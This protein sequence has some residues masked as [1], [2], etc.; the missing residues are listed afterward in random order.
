M[1]IK[2]PAAHSAC[3][4]TCNN[5]KL[6]VS[7]EQ[8]IDFSTRTESVARICESLR[9]PYSR[10][11][12]KGFVD[13][14]D[15]ASYRH[16]ILA[17]RWLE[18]NY[19]DGPDLVLL[20][21]RVTELYYLGLED[22]DKA[23]ITEDDIGLEDL[24]RLVDSHMFAAYN[25]AQYE[26]AR[27][28]IHDDIPTN[29][30]S[31]RH[32]F[33]P[34]EEAEQVPES[35]R[36]ATQYV[37]F[38]VLEANTASWEFQEFELPW[39]YKRRIVRVKVQFSVDDLSTHAERVSRRLALRDKRRRKRRRRFEEHEK[40]RVEM[41][42]G[43]EKK[44]AMREEREVK[45][46]EAAARKA[47]DQ[48]K[49]IPKRVREDAIKAQRDK[50]NV[51]LQSGVNAA[52]RRKLSQG[53]KRQVQ[54]QSLR[55]R[56]KALLIGGAMLF[57]AVGKTVVKG[58]AGTMN[59]IFKKIHAVLDRSEAITQEVKG[60]VDTVLSGLKA[61]T[62]YA[63]KQIK[64][65]LWTLP[66]IMTVH[67]ILRKVTDLPSL[68]SFTLATAL[69]QTV[70][71]ELWKHIS[72]FF[73][74]GNVVDVGVG[75][76]DNS[77]RPIKGD[78][79]TQKPETVEVEIQS[80]F[81]SYLST[82]SKLLSTVF[83][84]SVL[85]NGRANAVGEFC[86]RISM[87]GRMQDGW[88]AFLG[89]VSEAFQ[90][91]Y[92]TARKMFGKEEVHFLNSTKQPLKEWHNQVEK[93]CRKA[94]VEPS[95]VSTSDIDSMIKLY[96]TG[97]TL[98]EA[99]RSA[100]PAV[101]R[102][103]QLTLA[104][105]VTIYQPYKAA[106][107]ARNNFRMEP[108]LLLLRGEPGIGKTLMSTFLCTAVMKAS[109]LLPRDA[110]FDAVNGNIWQ[111]G[112][113]QFWNGYAGQHCLV[114]D[115]AFQNKADPTDCE[116]DYATIM[117]AVSTWAFPLN[118]AD[119][120]SKG[121][122]YF[123]SKFIYATTN[124]TSIQA[125]AQKV[126]NCVDA[127]N[128]RILYPYQLLLNPAYA[129]QEGR[130]DMVAYRRRLSEVQRSDDPLLAYPWDIWDVQEFDY[131]S[132]NPIGERR[133]MSTLVHT[134]VREM[135]TRMNS[136]VEVSDTLRKYVEGF[137]SKE[138]RTEPTII[139]NVGDSADPVGGIREDD[140]VSEFSTVDLQSGEIY[141]IPDELDEL[142]EKRAFSKLLDVSLDGLNKNSRSVLSMC[143][144]GKEMLFCAAA[145]AA[146]GV[147][148]YLL[149]K[150]IKRL[151]LKDDGFRDGAVCVQTHSNR[152]NTRR[153]PKKAVTVTVQSGCQQLIDNTRNN[154]RNV[155]FRTANGDVFRL[156]QVL[157]VV[158]RMFVQPA[159]Y[160][161]DVLDALSRK[162]ITLDTVM[163]FK[164]P[165]DL[166]TAA[167]VTVR[168]Y[169]NCPKYAVPETEV[170]FVKMDAIR[171]HRTIRSNFIRE[172]SIS[173]IGGQ[174]VVVSRVG[175]RDTADLVR[176]PSEVNAFTTQVMRVDKRPLR[177]AEGRLINK[178]VS[179]RFVTK[180]GDCGAPCCFEDSRHWSG[181]AILGIHVAGSV[182]GVP[183]GYA[184]I[185]TQEMIDEA[186]GL[187]NIL[188][189][190]FE[191]DLQARGVE[192]QSADILPFPGHSSFQP[193]GTV[194]KPVFISPATK[195][196]KTPLYGAF[197][198]YNYFPARLTAFKRDDEVIYPMLNAV[199]NYGTVVH[200][201]EQPWAKATFR[202][203][204]SQ[205]THLTADSSRKL[206]T[207]EEAVLGIPELKFRSIPRGTASGFPY[208]YSV[209]NGKKEFF[210]EEDEYDLTRPQCEDL[211]ERVQHVLSEAAK[212]NRL[213]H[214][215]VDFLKDELR[216]EEKVRTG[217]TRLISSAPLDYTIAWRMMFGSFSAAVMCTNTINGMAPGINA[218]S[219][220]HKLVD[221]MT[222][223][224]P[225]CFDGDFKAFDASELPCVHRL[226]LDY[227][228][229]WYADGAENARIREVLWADLVNSRHIGGLGKDQ[230]YI[231]QWTKSLPSGH[232][233]TT[234]VNSMYSLY[235]MAGCFTS[236]TG[237][238]LEFWHYVST[239]TYGDDNVN[240]VSDEVADVFNQTTVADAMER[241]FHLKYTPAQKGDVVVKTM[242]LTDMSF[243]KR[244]FYDDGS[245]WSCPLEL[246]SF[247]YTVYWCKNRKLRDIIMRDNLM[248]A[249][250]ELS[251]HP[252]EVYAKYAQSIHD[253]LHE[254]GF[255]PIFA[256][257]DQESYRDVVRSRKDAW[258]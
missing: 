182:S 237:K 15:H 140:A 142:M 133:P 48:R 174:Q 50:R 8:E 183:I 161:T 18:L 240:N 79:L 22:V 66:L 228:N 246:D 55:P 26:F 2:K 80:G 225:A 52:D 167:C 82:A 173:N 192:M 76:D 125:E 164:S 148:G 78:K 101:H 5:S 117:K 187:L 217:A 124:A 37:E 12:H 202:V 29:R 102:E 91:V 60:V 212:G 207:F 39:R 144:H 7:E 229:D 200:V 1:M 141:P 90:T 134:I 168:Y 253:R 155:Y 27:A 166:E 83:A 64:G 54:N 121:S 75:T 36:L 131:M 143:S 128:R 210:G 206:F 247:L 68:V 32:V 116:N 186:I 232:P 84:F 149:W 165:S 188:N 107:S 152:P 180:K 94:T 35:P 4:T 63:R 215:F 56:E 160:R 85:K 87:L 61:A 62:D 199:S 33:L 9:M 34:S 6:E 249:L 205:L 154:T 120:A 248:M 147:S 184:A 254:M 21:H 81:E 252:P 213:A 25:T 104:K 40:I 45:Q 236:L 126:I 17:V 191:E 28:G 201:F 16:R 93:I 220:W 244:G 146:I 239:V 135:N 242:A 175:I 251:L 258:Y 222:K 51:V 214:I 189:C 216:S 227:V 77:R 69:Q 53:Q 162:E 24:M 98:S 59:G 159:H 13:F 42:S 138:V 197:G 19:V 97:S 23:R 170:E 72:K 176:A 139:E 204:M 234:I 219:D 114:M 130:L 119:L 49:N 30:L 151:F 231:Y 172:E 67:F 122:I 112:N 88:E 233:F 113:S 57:G 89:W 46:R 145:V 105:L 99:W 245:A 129:T 169:L 31:A 65:A 230:R 171:A 74:G 150:V 14:C 123:S 177:T 86:K 250:E 73:P 96:V 38:P 43:Q 100:D 103:I 223:K 226:I 20:L 218:Y 243:L 108:I 256:A 193:L 111:K 255:T 58:L 44:K 115:D 235:T 110:D 47:K 211:R 118:F 224:G 109:G 190:K 179:Y 209:R 241:E 106:V 163:Y 137:S 157:W 95:E 41:Q 221:M 238:T 195:Y 10:N 3:V 185:V 196:H 127:V 158:D 71:K 132:G 156:G 11:F 178:Y 136:H 257:H 70:G 208:V 92:N 194:S 198:E 153:A 181:K 203:A